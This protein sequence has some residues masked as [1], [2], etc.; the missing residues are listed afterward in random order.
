MNSITLAR[1]R[2]RMNLNDPGCIGLREVRHGKC[3][4][5]LAGEP[6]V[7]HVFFDDLI[8]QAV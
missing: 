8:G 2:T 5:K 3:D 7:H 6:G 1:A 4:E